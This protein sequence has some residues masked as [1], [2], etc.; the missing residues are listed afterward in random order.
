MVADDP[1]SFADL[2][3][4]HLEQGYRNSRRFFST[5]IV[6]TKWVSDMRPK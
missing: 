1:E 2:D 6:K 4:H 3:G 5:L